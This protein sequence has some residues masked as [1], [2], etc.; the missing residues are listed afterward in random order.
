MRTKFTDVL[1]VV[2][3]LV[4]ASAIPTYGQTALNTTTL[5][6]AITSTSD[7]TV[8]VA[9]AT[10]IV[11]KTT[12]LYVDRELMPVTAVSGTVITVI[13]GG[14]GTKA[15]LHASSSAVYA[16]LLQYFSTTDR[17]GACTSTNEIALPVINVANGSVFDCRSS[18]TWI[19]IGY[20]SQR[21]GAA[22]S[23][24]AFCTGTAGSAETEYLNGAACSGATTATARQV[25]ASPGTLANLRVYSS[26][27]VVGGTNKDVLTVVKNG[28]DTALTCT[29]SA[30]AATCSD[31]T[32]SVA[33]VAG[34]VLTFK[35]VSATSDT[36]ANVS[37][38][39]EKF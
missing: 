15:T 22:E 9:S 10:G 2:A 27:N 14:G 23:F 35:F 32:H 13:R 18:G 5:S 34:D 8:R 3:I 12:A 28:S 4:M 1:L 21:S 16:G 36:A 11:A 29:I 30:S 6:A 37:I 38:G 17:Y 31:V 33:V 26:A 20:G 24:R 7:Q 19:P 39:L 25:V